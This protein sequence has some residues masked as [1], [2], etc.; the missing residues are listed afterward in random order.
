MNQ[1]YVEGFVKACEARGIDPEALVKAS[2]FGEAVGGVFSSLMDNGRTSAAFR[3]KPGFNGK[4]DYSAYTPV[5]QST[6]AVPPVSTNTPP[7]STNTPPAVSGQANLANS[8]GTALDSNPE[9]TK[10]IAGYNGYFTGV[11]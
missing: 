11:K 7:V 9:L 4:P 2:G 6:T 5:E 8:R 3:D 10:G 1:D